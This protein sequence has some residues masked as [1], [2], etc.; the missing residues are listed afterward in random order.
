LNSSV[1]SNSKNNSANY[2][3]KAS[4]ELNA[5]ANCAKTVTDSI[6]PKADKMTKAVSNIP[7]EPLPKDDSMPSTKRGKGNDKIAQ[8]AQQSCGASATG[9]GQRMRRSMAVKK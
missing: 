8:Q 1:T 5:T 2:Q 4:I 7:D 9:E 6:E 3:Q